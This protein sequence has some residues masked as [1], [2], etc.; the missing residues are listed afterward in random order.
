MRINEEVSH[1]QHVAG[2]LEG[3]G[4]NTRTSAV[5]SVAYRAP[6]DLLAV[7]DAMASHSGKSRNSMLNLLLQSGIDEV[8]ENLS[9]EVIEKLSI[10]EAKAIEALGVHSL[11]T[12]TE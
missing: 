6:I 2:I 10:A 11:E 4:S 12:L 3:T 8:R 9:D 5:R 7:V 1:A